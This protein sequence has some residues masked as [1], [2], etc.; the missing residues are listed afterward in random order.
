M[1]PGNSPVQRF[2]AW[3]GSTVHLCLEKLRPVISL[4]H[5]KLTASVRLQPFYDLPVLHG[6]FLPDY[7]YQNGFAVALPRR[8]QWRLCQFAKELKQHDPVD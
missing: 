4:C 1:Q 3:Y 5:C 7:E 8:P 6:T 2:T